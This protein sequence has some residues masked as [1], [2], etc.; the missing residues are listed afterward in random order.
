[1][2]I[3]QQTVPADWGKHFQPREI[4]KLCYDAGWTDAQRLLFA[5]SVCIA[6]SNGY[7]QRKNY[8]YDSTGALLSTDRGIWMLND[9]A[10]PDVSDE[11]AYDAVKATAVARKIY[12]AHNGFTPWSS[13][14]NL[15]FRGPRAMGYAFDGVAN[16]LRVKNGFPL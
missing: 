15:Q 3:E 16:F 7:E 6:E 11:V 5:V 4:A 9:K 14:G 1:M 2:T 8:N 13:F 12:T 10:H